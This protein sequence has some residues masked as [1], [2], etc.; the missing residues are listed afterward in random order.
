M[1]NLE[2][3]QKF[4]TEAYGALCFYNDSQDGY[5]AYPS[6]SDKSVETLSIYFPN[7]LDLY[8]PEVKER[9][10]AKYGKEVYD[11]YDGENVPMVGALSGQHLIHVYRIGG[12]V[13]SIAD[14]YFLYRCG[15][16]DYII[17]Y[18]LGQDISKYNLAPPYDTG[19]T[20]ATYNGFV[21][22]AGDN[23]KE[24]LEQFLRQHNLPLIN[25]GNGFFQEV[26]YNCNRLA[27]FSDTESPLRVLNER[28]DIYLR[29]YGEIMTKEEMQKQIESIGV[30]D[31]ARTD[32]FD[33]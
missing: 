5:Y 16:V 29:K 33:D 26:Y 28:R 4:I 14:E 23:I 21:L 25:V 19:K 9:I 2:Y 11:K 20:V 32:E 3:L 13:V 8:V 31:V 30:S 10:I 1:T 27:G 7:K 18:F 24:V 15:G 6:E 22:K 17:K 12:Q